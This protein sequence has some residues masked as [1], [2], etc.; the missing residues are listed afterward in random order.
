MRVRANNHEIITTLVG[1]FVVLGP[2]MV[3]HLLGGES[4]IGFYDHM[5]D[6]IFGRI[7]DILELW[8]R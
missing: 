3:E 8:D 2:W 1:G 5:F 4:L 6:E 7:S